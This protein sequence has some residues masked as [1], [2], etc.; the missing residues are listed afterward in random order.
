MLLRGGK[1]T[2]VVSDVVEGEEDG[3]SKEKACGANRRD[4]CSGHIGFD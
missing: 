1:G 3:E 2:G 4:I